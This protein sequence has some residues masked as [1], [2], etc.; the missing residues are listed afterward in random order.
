MS[1]I[2]SIFPVPIYRTNVKEIISKEDLDYIKNQKQ[3]SYKNE[4]NFTSKD[5][6]I[7][8]DSRYNKIQNKMMEHIN[9]YFKEVIDTSDKVI[10]YI[11]Q[12]WL[13]FTKETQ[14]HHHH[15]HSN[16]FVSGVLYISADKEQ[17]LITFHKSNTDQI[18][19]KPKNYNLYNSRSWRFPVE[20]GDLFLFPA[21]LQHS[22]PKKE[23]NNLRISLAFNVF[24]KGSLGRE[25]DLNELLL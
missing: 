17:D 21:T 13:N 22:V 15:S 25:K 1:E 11:T 19:L 23:G 14:F 8:K 5:T 18:E 24:I 16:S 4:G 20:T 6:Y 12:S 7:F 9:E 2:K 3:V 10:P